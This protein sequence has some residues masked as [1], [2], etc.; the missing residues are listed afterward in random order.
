[1]VVFLGCIC[2]WLDLALIRRQFCSNTA[3]SRFAT[4][5]LSKLFDEVFPIGTTVSSFWR[6]VLQLTLNE[7]SNPDTNK[8]AVIVTYRFG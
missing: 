4:F 7:E 2:H 1:M 8:A 3:K 6:T 5:H